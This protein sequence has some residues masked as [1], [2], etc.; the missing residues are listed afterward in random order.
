MPTGIA[1]RNFSNTAPVTN[2]TAPIDN[3]LTTTNIPVTSTAGFPPVP[4]T[5]CMDRNTATQEFVLVSSV[6]DANHFLVIRGYDSTPAVAHN[7]VPAPATFE[8]CT[9]AIDFREANQH[10]TDSTRD[11]HLQ[12][13]NLSGVRPFIGQQTFNA[14]I[15]AQ[16]LALSGFPGSNIATRYVGGTGPTAQGPPGAGTFLVGDWIRDIVGVVWTCVVA[17]SPGTWIPECGRV[18][19]SVKGP[20]GLGLDVINST[21]TLISYTFSAIKNVQY[22]ANVSIQ[23]TIVTAVPG[24]INCIVTGSAGT[25]TGQIFVMSYNATA[26]AVNA[27][28]GGSLTFGLNVLAATANTTVTVTAAASVHGAYRLSATA[29]QLLIWRG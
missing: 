4:F 19:H 21:H 29:A 1:V 23:G 26:L 6:I 25:M 8:H 7:I 24:Y 13:A 15:N 20:G 10:H 28:M 18:M 27:V 2:L 5:G 16:T 17:G 3:A 12:Y 14:G 11:D 22:I 9:G